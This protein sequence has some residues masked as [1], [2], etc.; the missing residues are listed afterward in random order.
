MSE[1]PK[2]SEKR[3]HRRVLIDAYVSAA[4]VP[5]DVLQ[6]RVFLSQDASPDGIFLLTNEEFPV[7]T[8]MRLEINLPSTFKPIEVEARVARVAKN[9]DG[10]IAGVGLIFTNISEPEKKGLLKHLY[11]AYHYRSAQDKKNR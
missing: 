2:P 5:K 8:L 9:K 11:L 7:G 10:Q 1:K 3:S 6:E 4:L